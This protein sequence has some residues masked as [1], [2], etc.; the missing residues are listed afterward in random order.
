MD[1]ALDPSRMEGSFLRYPQLYITAHSH[2]AH[3]PPWM[4]MRIPKTFNDDNFF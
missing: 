3:T 2:F 4:L 1:N